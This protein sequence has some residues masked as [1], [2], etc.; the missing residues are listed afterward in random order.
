MEQG[1]GKQE[2]NLYV[3]KLKFK[4]SIYETGME[5]SLFLLNILIPILYFL[6]P[7]PFFNP[8]KSIFQIHKIL[9]KCDKIIKFKVKILSST[10]SIR[11]QYKR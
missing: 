4:T 3:C 8:V 1:N 2:L 5:E 9:C 6:F 10:K 11:K 7:I